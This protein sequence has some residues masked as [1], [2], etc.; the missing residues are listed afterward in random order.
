M[1]TTAS[2]WEE[3]LG[4]VML[5]DPDMSWH[6]NAACVGSRLDFF[7]ATKPPSFLA[8]VCADC[9]ARDR[10]LEWALVNRVEHGI[11]GG[12][13]TPERKALVKAQGGVWRSETRGRRPAAA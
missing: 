4:S 12:M 5:A 13:S 6:A 11:W 8:E 9:P 10:C 3:L 1:T 2:V 7:P